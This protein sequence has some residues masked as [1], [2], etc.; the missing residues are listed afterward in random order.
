MTTSNKMYDMTKG[1]PTALLLKFSLPMVI[2]N[3]FQ[4]FYNMVDAIV[5]GQFVGANALASVGATGSITFLFFSLVIG[6]SS[7]VGIIVSQYYGAKEMDKVQ[8]TIAT[9]IYVITISAILMAIVTILAARPIMEMLDTPA[10]IIGDSVVY[11]RVVGAGIIAVGI[12]NGTA[13]I[14]RAL[15]D[16]KTPLIFL[17]VAAILNVILDLLFVLMLNMGVLGVALATVISQAVSGIGCVLYAWIKMPLFRIPLKACV[18]DTSIFKKCLTLGI[19]VALQSSMI[20]ISCI[21]LQKFVNGF[22]PTIMAAFTVAGRFE[23]LIQQPF[24]SLGAA[25]ATYTGQNMGANNIERIKK[26]FWSAAKISTIFSLF[27]LPVAWFGGEGIMSLFTHEADVIR[28]GA[29][30]IS[31]TCF[32]YS[33][34]GMI[35]VTRSLLNGAGDVRFAMISGIAEVVGRVG[36]AKPLMLV[37]G[38]GMLSIWYT[39]GL[40]WLLTAVISCIRYAGGKWMSKGIVKTSV[41]LDKNKRIEVNRDLNQGVNREIS[42]KVNSEIDKELNSEIN[43][44]VNKEVDSVLEVQINQAINEETKIAYN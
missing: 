26:G 41:D 44:E 32:F 8:K 1:N 11:L 25:L 34:L 18:M 2:G 40:T 14:L 39:T 23:Q 15:G 5:V 21:M 24:N 4:Q 43:R 28:E 19:P 6:L 16:S 9:A 27:M 3:I 35:Y 7:G 29:R 22:G 31:I 33:A 10:E 36:L 37:P 38:I 12:Y 30:G 17:I 20:A 42:K 13:S